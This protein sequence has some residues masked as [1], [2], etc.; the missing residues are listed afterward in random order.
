VGP[1]G[2]DTLCQSHEIAEASVGP[3]AHD[4]MHMVRQ[5]GLAQYPNTGLV[6]GAGDRALHVAGCGVVDASHTL[7]GVPRD[8]GVELIRV[9]T[10]HGT[11]FP[12]PGRKP[13]EGD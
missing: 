9:V 4:H 6:A 13:G 7:P 3:E 5:D 8:V 11:R 1:Q 12:D 2:C 10:G